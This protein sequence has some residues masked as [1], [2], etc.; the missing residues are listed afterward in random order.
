MKIKVVAEMQRRAASGVAAGSPQ[1]P[2]LT[3]DFYHAHVPNAPGRLPDA[4]SPQSELLDVV[5]CRLCVVGDYH[6]KPDPSD[7][8]PCGDTSGSYGGREKTSGQN[9]RPCRVFPDS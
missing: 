4:S 2:G 1:R 3:V 7:S 8:P 6:E 5:Q 9:L